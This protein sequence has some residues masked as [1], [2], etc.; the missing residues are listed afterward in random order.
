MLGKASGDA[1]LILHPDQIVGLENYRD[2]LLHSCTI[3]IGYPAGKI[4]I[5]ILKEEDAAF[6]N[7]NV[8]FDKTTDI[9]DNVTCSITRTVEFGILFTSDMDNAIIRCSVQQNSFP[10][11]PNIY[12]NN[13]TVSLIPSKLN[14]FFYTIQFIFRDF[15]NLCPDVT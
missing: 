10:N 2:W 12:S 15:Y 7:M 9:A 6:K 1:T 13:E 14:A 4:E 11:D 8:N 3:D 5:E